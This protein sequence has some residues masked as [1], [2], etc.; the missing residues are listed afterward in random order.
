MSRSWLLSL[1]AVRFS[2]GWSLHCLAP[3]P[4]LVSLH[5]NIWQACMTISHP[6]PSS[7]SPPHGQRLPNHCCG[8]S[9]AIPGEH[10]PWIAAKV[11]CAYMRESH[12]S[13]PKLYFHFK[14]WILSVRTYL[15]RRVRKRH[16]QCK[17]CNLFS[18]AAS[19]VQGP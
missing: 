4:H 18:A 16:L 6:N 9:S 13:D 8:R 12:L 10:V 11:E 7:T 1:V 14:I 15:G 3:P 19:T 5:D 17:L 2:C